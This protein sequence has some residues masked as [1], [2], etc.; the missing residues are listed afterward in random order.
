MGLV[1]IL[2]KNYEKN[3]LVAYLIPPIVYMSQT[4]RHDLEKL[5][6]GICNNTLISIEYK[7]KKNN[8]KIEITKGPFEPNLHRV[9]LD[10]LIP[11][12]KG[13][14]VRTY[15][16]T[17]I[18]GVYAWGTDATIPKTEVKTFQITWNENSIEIPKSSYSNLYELR[19][20]SK[21]SKVE[22][23]LTENGLLY[24]YMDASDGAGSYSVKFVFDNTK[25]LTKFI[26]ANEMV[27]G[28]D[29]LDCTAEIEED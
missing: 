14:L 29:S 6:D 11:N 25:Y 1:K 17:R 5:N 21:Y 20:C 26:S 3:Y 7:S 16:D 23:Y 13:D 24:I 28:F 22:A 27:D 10:S 15:I 4:D 19:I 2:P 9:V 8:I 18:D 12:A